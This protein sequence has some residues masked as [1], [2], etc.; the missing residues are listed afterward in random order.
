MKELEQLAQ[1]NYAVNLAKGW[2]EV[3]SPNMRRIKKALIHSEI[4]EALECVRDL[5]LDERTADSGKPEGLPVEIADV[6]LRALDYGTHTGW[7]D[8]SGYSYPQFS[9]TRS[10]DPVVLGYYLAELHTLLERR[11]L[12]DLVDGCFRLA[13]VL[14]VDLLAVARRKLEF[15]RTRQHRHGGRAL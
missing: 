15:N 2:W 3:D 5:D 9:V 1:D 6:L 8:W 11:E 7:V 13:D 4:S 14:G 12:I 10:S